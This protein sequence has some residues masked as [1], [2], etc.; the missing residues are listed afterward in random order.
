[1][2]DYGLDN[3]LVALGA[4]ILVISMGFLAYGLLASYPQLSGSALSSAI[5][6]MV[7]M[8]IGLTYTDPLSSLLSIY[9]K[10]ISVPLVKLVEDLGLISGGT[11]QA[12]VSEDT[13]TIV[14]ARKTLPC[15]KIK[16]G[17]GIVDQ[18]PY[19]A[20]KSQ[21]PLLTEDLEGALSKTGI[22]RAVLVRNTGK[23]I[24][25]ELHG[26]PLGIEGELKPL[27]L[28][29]VVI[30]IYTATYLGENIRLEEEEYGEDYYKAVYGV[31][32]D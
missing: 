20:L 6:G 19:I 29:Q 11:L 21:A 24:T 8:T 27:N 13:V 31:I 10:T 30:P 4:V 25:I 16:P 28:Y 7:F 32:S 3:R 22:A 9:N 17:L 26:L 1:M 14:Y 15:R 5:L 2:G 12:C 18:T 23:N